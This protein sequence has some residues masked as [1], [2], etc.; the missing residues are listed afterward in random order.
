[1]P[2]G[3]TRTALHCRYKAQRRAPVP[4]LWHG[5]RR[6]HSCCRGCLAGLARLIL[7]QAGPNLKILAST[8]RLCRLLPGES[9]RKGP[10]PLGR[11]VGPYRSSPMP[12]IVIKPTRPPESVRVLDSNDNWNRN[13]AAVC[14]HPAELVNLSITSPHYGDQSVSQATKFH[15]VLTGI[16]YSISAVSASGRRLVRCTLGSATASGLP[17]PKTSSAIRWDGFLSRGS[18]NGLDRGDAPGA[19]QDALYRGRPYYLGPGLEC[20]RLSGEG[21]ADRQQGC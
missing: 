6:F 10:R 9:R 11:P 16:C 18:W 1:M 15:P 5:L 3:R 13:I 14:R 12:S 19:S 17:R 2:R 7:T 8:F 20:M 4:I 21:C